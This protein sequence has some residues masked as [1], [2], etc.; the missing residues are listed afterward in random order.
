MVRVANRAYANVKGLLD[1]NHGL[2]LL[3]LFGLCRWFGNRLRFLHLLL[4]FNDLRRFCLHYRDA[5]H[6]LLLFLYRWSGIL[7]RSDVFGLLLLLRLTHLR[8]T[9]GVASKLQL[10]HPNAPTSLL[11]LDGSLLLLLLHDRRAEGNASEILALVLLLTHPI[12]S[13]HYWMGVLLLLLL[14]LLH[15]LVFVVLLFPH[16][17]EVYKTIRCIRFPG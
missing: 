8:V 2:F 10:I 6:L 5:L 14:R 17:L 9:N 7:L 12:R 1:L 11:T 13:F 16:V 4:L 15:L 3:L